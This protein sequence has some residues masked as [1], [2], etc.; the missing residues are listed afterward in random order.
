M[1]LEYRELTLP[2]GLPLL[3]FGIPPPTT[4]LG[5][6]RRG[7]EVGWGMTDFPVT[8]VYLYS[9]FHSQSQVNRLLDSMVN[10]RVNPLHLIPNVVASLRLRLGKSA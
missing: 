8:S 2:L 5:R 10:S 9:F 1:A 3:P 7:V 6:V 4:V